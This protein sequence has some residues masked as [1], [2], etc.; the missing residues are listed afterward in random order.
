MR[1]AVVHEWLASHAGSEK[2]V[3]QILQLYP[4][5]DLFSLVDF[6]SPEQR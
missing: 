2:V 3:E 1:V 4:D 5:A 6:L